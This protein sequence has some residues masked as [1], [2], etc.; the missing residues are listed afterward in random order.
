MSDIA[1]AI[2]V[3]LRLD[4]VTVNG[5]F[6]HY[7][8]VLVDIDLKNP[9]LYQIEVDSTSECGFVNVEYSNIL[10]FYTTCSSIG[11]PATR[12]KLN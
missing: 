7:A 10:G 6:G 2:V 1:Q 12:C 5:D 8:R 3:P 11:H 4:Q 9:L